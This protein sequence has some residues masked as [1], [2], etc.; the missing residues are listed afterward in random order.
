VREI[1]EG[2][3]MNL[4]HPIRA[5]VPTL[6]GP[7]LEVLV[8]TTL[9]LTG[10]EIHRLAGTGSPNGVRHVLARL[11]EQGLVHAEERA[12]AVF[13]VANRDHVAWPAVELLTSLRRALLDRLRAEVRSWRVKP[14]HASL[15]GS[16]ARTEGGDQSDVDVLLVRPD[17]VEEDQAPWA[18]QV[19]RL[20][21]QVWAWTGN[22]CQAFQVDLVRLAEHVRVRDPLIDAWLRD[23]IT[24][25]GPDLRAILRRLPA[26]GGDRR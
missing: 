14:V 20:R 4:A 24:L 15:F 9:P 5:V 13:Y 21:H 1:L 19:D 25:A 7:V 22:R 26:V 12:R 16:A 18:D 10:R 23:A 6:D 11:T 8:G 17:E 2:K 3:P